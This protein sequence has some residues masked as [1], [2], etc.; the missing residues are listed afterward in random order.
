LTADRTAA[1][2]QPLGSAS[3]AHT[4]LGDAALR[5][6]P[7]AAMG[8]TVVERGVDFALW[9]PRA[10]R[11][12]LC[13]FDAAGTHELQRLDLHGPRSAGWQ[14]AWH[15]HLAGATAGLVYGFRVHGP[16]APRE[17]HR[18]NPAKLLLDP[19]A[20]AVVGHYAGQAS[21]LGHDA[22]DAMRPSAVDNAAD[23][24]K[25]K[26]VAPWAPSPR[27]HRR[28]DD[29]AVVLYEVHV[30]AATKLHPGVPEALR[31]TYAGLAHPA[32]V[33]HVKALGVTTLSLLPVHQRTDEARL[34][35]LGLTNHWG[36]NPLAFFAAEP[37]YAQDASGAMAEFRAMVAALHDAGLEVVLDVVYNHT[38]ET[39]ELG[40]TFH[41]RGIDNAAYY[42]QR[43]GWP[44][45]ASSP[46]ENWTGCGNALNLTEPRVVQLVVDSLR[47]WATAGG[48]D[49]FR[50]D[51]APVLARGPHGFSQAAGFFAAI[52]ADPLLRGLRL[53]AEPWDIGPGGYRLGAFPPPWLE[54]NDRFRDTMRGFWLTGHASRG[55]FAHHLAGSSGDFRKPGRSALSS[56]NFVTA[57]DGFTLRDLVSFERKHNEANGEHNR[58]GHDHNRSI[59]G[60][61]EGPSDDPA[62]NDL[63][64]RLQRA[65]LTTLAVAQGTPMLLAGD[66]IG[67]SQHG[68]NNAYCQDNTITWLDWPNADRGLLDFTRRV[69]ALR[70]ECAVLRSSVWHDGRARERAGGGDA[71]GS[72]DSTASATTP[73]LSWFRPDGHP[74]T[75]GD[76]EHGGH[77]ALQARFAGC[78]AARGEGGEGGEGG[79]VLLLMNPTPHDS[80]MTLPSPAGGSRWMGRLR[81]DD[82]AAWVQPEVLAASVTLPPRCLWIAVAAA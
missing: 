60:G 3:L 72:T 22:S 37:R 48:V 63:R 76:W 36:Y 77:A 81:S 47:H 73:D 32:F 58:D 19:Y 16:W 15:G 46:Y 25:A 45:H 14:G 62:V 82:A 33:D 23:A 7:R 4:R 12:E 51:L 17:G 78:E 21:F 30:K 1:P 20:Q 67:H 50:F 75:P 26:V 70:R 74:M 66:E 68:N 43:A 38:A 28:V 56:V 5:P 53:I 55:A 35:R 42:H 34:L 31:G 69:L 2:S 9:A 79:A 29:D 65:L 27:A 61:V 57:H 54:W 59:N 6:A 39:D 52:Q 64:S 24:P 40:P 13:L 8:S 71:A 18:F 80:P 44:D 49:G 10:D 41:F 11:V